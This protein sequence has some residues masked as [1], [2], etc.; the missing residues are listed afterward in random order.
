MKKTVDL[1]NPNFLNKDIQIIYKIENIK[2]LGYETELIQVLINILNNSKDALT[3]I[4]NE[5]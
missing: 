4:E 5:K 1:I 3:S 2:I